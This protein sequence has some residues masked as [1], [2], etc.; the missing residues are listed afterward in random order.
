[1][2][3]Q[4]EEEAWA[5]R[6]ALLPSPLLL[7]HPGLAPPGAITKG[8]PKRLGAGGQK[9]VEGEGFTQEQQL[10]GNVLGWVARMG[11]GGSRSHGVHGVG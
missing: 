2:E 11:A 6:T 8:A 10:R 9:Q 3:K 4:G 7:G 1:M 5:G